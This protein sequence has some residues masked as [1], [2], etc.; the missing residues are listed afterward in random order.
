M[1]VRNTTEMVLVDDFQVGIHFVGERYKKLFNQKLIDNLI[2]KHNFFIEFQISRFVL[3]A[4][5][6]IKPRELTTTEKSILASW[7]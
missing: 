5:A 7:H 6:K 4:I 2:P 3:A 1:G